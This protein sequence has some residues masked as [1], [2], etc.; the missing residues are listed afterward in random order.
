MELWFSCCVSDPLDCSLP[1]FSVCGVLQARILER[2]AVAASC[3]LLRFPSVELVMPSSHFALCCPLLLLPSVFLSIR[4][5]SSQ[6][7]PHHPVAKNWN[8]SFRIS[9]PNEH[10]GLASL[11]LD[12]F[13]PHAVRRTLRSLPQH[14]NSKASFFGAQPCLWPR[15]HMYATGKGGDMSVKFKVQRFSK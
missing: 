11:R 15:S 5:F 7:A 14:C 9:R 8:F 13:D 4:V 10:S 1:D 12:R 6:S 2:V 3:S